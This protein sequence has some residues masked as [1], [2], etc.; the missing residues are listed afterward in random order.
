M[1]RA[2]ILPALIAAG[3]HV[4]LLGFR[5]SPSPLPV[6][7]RAASDQPFPIEEAPW[8]VIVEEPT[9]CFYTFGTRCAWFPQLRPAPLSTGYVSRPIRSY[10]PFEPVRPPALNLALRKCDLIGANETTLTPKRSKQSS[11]RGRP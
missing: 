10:L 7:A 9:G 2:M 1:N 11:N 8:C 3:L 4:A 6:P 5:I